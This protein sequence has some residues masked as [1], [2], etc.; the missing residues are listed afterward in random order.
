VRRKQQIMDVAAG[1]FAERGFHRVTV[2]ELGAALGVSGPALYHHFPSK[3]ALL[4]DMLVSISEQLLEGGRKRVATA[5]TPEDALVALLR[6]HIQFSL[7]RTDLITVHVRDLVHAPEASYQR[8]RELQGQYV[9]VLVGVLSGLHPGLDAREA[10]AAVHAVFGL[11]N[12]TPHSLR[13]S[14][15]AMSQLLLDM[16]LASFAAVGERAELASPDAFLRAL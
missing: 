8:V 5:A 12:S 9:Q 11:L 4:G 3:E 2:D 10:R 14:R 6:G 7:D 16:A 15:A 1:L 13:I